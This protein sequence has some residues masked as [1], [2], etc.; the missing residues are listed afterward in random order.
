MPYVFY[1]TE[2]TGIETTFDQILQF[3]A[4]KTDDDLN[5]LERVNIRCRLL[6]HI[7]PSP[8]ALQVTHVTPAMLTDSALPSHY[9]MIRQVRDTLLAW[10]PATFIGFNSMSFDE[11]LLR[12]ALF[13]TLHP[14]YLTNTNGNARSDALRVAH[15]A[16]VYTPDVMVVP[17]DDRGRQVFRLD[18]LAHANGYNGD[19]AHEAMADVETTIFM[20]RLIRDRAPDVWKAM[21]R[22]T[23]KNAV[24]DYVATESLFSLTESYFGKT[25][26]WLVTPCGQNPKDAGQLSVFDLSFDP[27]DYR[28]LSAEDL[29]AVLNASP[30]AIRFL[31]ANR[32]PI[33]MPADAAPDNTRALQIPPGERR[34]RVEVIRGDPDFQARV[35]QAQ[36]LRFADKEPPAHVEQRIYDGFSNAADEALMGQFHQADWGE[37]TALAA[38]IE[39][40]RLG[41]FARRLIYFERPEILSQAHS[42]ELSAWIAN[43]VLTE[44]DSVPWM[45]VRKALRETDV[46]LRNA[47]GEEAGLLSEVRDFLYSRAEEIAAG[48]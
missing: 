29:V 6:P 19:D 18:N 9:E 46:L 44:D 12:Q 31:R 42:T 30:K 25:Y 39:D 32:Q 23:T 15:A 27:D 26:S 7:I 3:A 17:T 48:G 41:E 38:Q 5:E 33:M 36:A 16:S 34:R 2:T 47:R 10:S 43:R 22:A 28:F 45:T 40:P 1:D 37:R 4:I 8:I 21:D 20:V 11:N 24:K 13:Q 14:A 35:G